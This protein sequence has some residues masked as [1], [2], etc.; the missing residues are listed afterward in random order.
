MYFLR[1]GLN[2]LKH[3]NIKVIL[4][5]IV[6]LLITISTIIII[7]YVL[8]LY[9]ITTEKIKVFAESFGVMSIFVLIILMMLSVMSPLPDTP[10]A[11]AAILIYGP[12]GGFLIAYT[13]T[14]L[15][16][17]T[18]FY[19]ARRLGREYFERKLPSIIEISNNFAKKYGFEV[20]VFLR[21][22][23]SVTF[24]I[25]AY[26]AALTKIKTRI[27]IYATMVGAV[28][29]AVNYI[30]IS[31]GIASGN[32]YQIM[33]ALLISSIFLLSLRLIMKY[34]LHGKQLDLMEK[35]LRD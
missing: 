32:I 29:P 21:I 12:G 22:F 10:V 5:S 13:G 14:I 26:S 16:A 6:A 9:G 25:A 17:I 34:A 35:E 19:I 15:G 20:I 33:G 28:I 18:N 31:S 7:L 1:K 23:P 24:D 11:V 4:N 8:N 2:K 30:I 27:F 3:I